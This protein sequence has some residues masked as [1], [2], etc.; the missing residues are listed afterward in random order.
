VDVDSLTEE[1]FLTDVRARQKASWP[2]NV[3]TEVSYIH[4]EIPLTEYL[5]RRA[6]EHPDRVAYNFYGRE[7]TFAELDALSDKFGAY[8]LSQSVVPGDRVGVMLPN[9]PQFVIS[10]Y[11]ILKAGAVHV[12]INPMFREA[13]ISYE[14]QDSE[15]S[16]ILVL[17]SLAPQVERV[18]DHSSIRRMVTTSIKEYVPE[19]P[20]LPLPADFDAQAAPIAGAASWADVL[21][22]E[23]PAQWPPV[24]LDALAAL[25]YTGGTTGMPKGCEHTQRHMLYTAA[26]TASTRFFG[27]AMGGDQPMVS[28][29]FLPVFWIAGEN[30]G[31]IY[32]IYAGTT[33]VLLTRWDPLAMLKAV[34]L[35]KVNA[36]GG[37]VDNY[38]E[39]MGRGDFGDYDLTS[40]AAPATMSFVTKMAPE[41]R[42]KWSS[43]VGEHSVLH[44][45]SYG[46]TETHT[47]DSF[48]AGFQAN[49]YDLKA[50]PVF[51]GLPMPGTDF[52]IRDFN[53]GAVLPI[54]AEG[55]ICVRT[56]SLMTAYWNKPDATASAL[57]NGWFYT[58]DIG[59]ITEDGC[60]HFLGRSKEMLKVNG[61]SVFPSELE[62]LLSQ[63]PDIAAAAVI[64]IPDTER[65]EAPLAFVL[66]QPE[67]VGRVDAEQIRAWCKANMA[68]Y[69]LPLVELIQEM[70]LTATGKIKKH[71][72]AER[73]HSDHSHAP[74]GV[75]DRRPGRRGSPSGKRGRNITAD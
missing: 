46:M 40:I 68:G 4:G 67:S 53:T 12:P 8:L 14:L 41:F 55:E 51:C 48:I 26:A 65:G 29:S 49:D 74:T 45:S 17:D 36:T 13:E 57:R 20:D 21:A 42:R 3:P 11:G 34:D 70:P 38:I 35:Y 66:L 18:G 56:P 25:N 23:M 75:T 54:G 62:V 71:V 9:C 33:C 59:Q 50:R 28:L 5:R 63:N 10:F 60:L 1:L 15:A 37:T 43:L 44:E 39:L 19:Q 22:S 7:I 30:I 31:V 58:G 52:T 61:M 47:M 72:L 27:A 6:R 2:G 32:P 24:S 73:L 64:G 16:L 69:K